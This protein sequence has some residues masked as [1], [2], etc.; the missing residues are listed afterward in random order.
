[1][2]K[3][4]LFMMDDAFIQRQPFGVSLIMGAWN[5]PVQLALGPLVGAIA[6]GNAAI[7]KPSD[8]SPATADLIGEFHHQVDDR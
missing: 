1:V 7:L 6:A 3:G 2:K 8:V 4:L 5:Y